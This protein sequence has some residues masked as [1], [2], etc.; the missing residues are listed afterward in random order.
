MFQMVN[1]RETKKGIQGVPNGGASFSRQTIHSMTNSSQL[2][3]SLCNPK[4]QQHYND[5]YA[6]YIACT[7]LSTPLTS[8]QKF[9][10]Q[11]STSDKFKLPDDDD[12]DALALGLPVKI[13][14][15]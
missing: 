14:R 10:T 3:P 13:M 15:V 9:N 1:S 7:H 5:Q 8:H 4:F 11:P 12:K 6:T 2:S